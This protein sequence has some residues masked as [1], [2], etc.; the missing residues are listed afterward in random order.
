METVAGQQIKKEPFQTAGK[1]ATAYAPSIF[2]EWR[3]EKYLQIG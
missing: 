1:E 3:I 2:A